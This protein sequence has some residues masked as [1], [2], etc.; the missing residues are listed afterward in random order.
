MLALL[1]LLVLLHRKSNHPQISEHRASYFN[2]VRCDLY[3]S[4][5][6]ENGWRPFNKQVVKANKSTKMKR[7]NRLRYLGL[8]SGPR[9]ALQYATLSDFQP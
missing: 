2:P 5:V 6:N 7:Y 9:V 8:L 1:V 3:V 4:Y